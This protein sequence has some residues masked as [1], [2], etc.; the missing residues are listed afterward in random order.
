MRVVGL[1]YGFGAGM[2]GGPLLWLRCD[3]ATMRAERSVREKASRERAGVAGGGSGR[4]RAESEKRANAR[5]EMGRE[6]LACFGK[7]FT[8]IF[9]VK[10]FPFFPLRFYGQRQTFSG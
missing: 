3:G 5:S 7:W 2:L 10:H 4:Q 1:C 8:E 6:L 9:S